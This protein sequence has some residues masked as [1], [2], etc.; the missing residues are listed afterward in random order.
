MTSKIGLA[1][2]IFGGSGT[3]DLMAADVYSVSEESSKTSFVS[4]LDNL[5]YKAAGYIRDN[6]DTISNLI[7]FASEIRNNKGISLL[8][9][10]ARVKQF[11]PNNILSSISGL[12]DK[13]TS[14]ITGLAE[15]VGV[16]PELVGLVK[17]TAGNVAGQLMNAAQ[18]GGDVS[19]FDLLR[20]LVDDPAVFS[21]LNLEYEVMMARE[22][23]SQ[24]AGSD[25]FTDMLGTWENSYDEDVYR[26]GLSYAVPQI[27]YVGDISSM[28]AVI[29]KIGVAAFVA[30]TPNA[31]KDILTSF[32]IPYNTPVSGYAEQR[33]LLVSAIERIAPH[34]PFVKGTVTGAGETRTGTL[35]FDPV[36]NISEDA[37]LLFL[38]SNNT[39]YQTLA[40][41]GPSFPM[42][43]K[44]SMF[45]E[46][47]PDAAIGQTA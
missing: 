31:V 40:L 16:S 36:M 9:N 42:S 22:I 32:K 20:T 34:F 8:E 11:I 46:F 1:N 7:S 19:K 28:N 24:A 29:D 25:L 10:V 45:S 33:N 12:A 26:Y 37:K 3:D 21:Y 38:T 27:I 30:Q 2:T 47:Y 6:P 23:Y 18:Y 5:G 14:V 44:E 15:K 39:D 13:G 17:S 35:D 41:H 43:T 4:K